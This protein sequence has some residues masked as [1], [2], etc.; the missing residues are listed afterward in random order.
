[1]SDQLE[2]STHMGEFCQ[3]CWND[4]VQRAAEDKSKSVSEHYGRLLTERDQE[5]EA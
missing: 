3:R 4:A 1:M 5:R 2:C